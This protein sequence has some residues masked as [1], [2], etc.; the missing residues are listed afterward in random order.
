M[1]AS[2]VVAAE[3]STAA[4]ELLR[5]GSV[6]VL[7][8]IIIKREGKIGF[9]LLK[10]LRRPEYTI[11]SSPLRTTGSGVPFIFSLFISLVYCG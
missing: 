7:G 8:P 3:G 1:G 6:G 2:P 11:Q 10:R 9:M 4:M 5:C